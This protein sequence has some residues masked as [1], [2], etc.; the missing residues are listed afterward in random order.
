[1]EM[2]ISAVVSENSSVVARQSFRE[3]RCET[4]AVA[5]KTL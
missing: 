2:P 3:V 5:L 1:M 4:I